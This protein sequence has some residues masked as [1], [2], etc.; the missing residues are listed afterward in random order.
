MDLAIAAIIKAENLDVTDEE[1]EEK[2]KSM[3]EQ[4]GM[5][6]RCSRSISTHLPS[7]ISF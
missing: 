5:E 3:A 2:Y 6:S 7:A 1:I 4:Y